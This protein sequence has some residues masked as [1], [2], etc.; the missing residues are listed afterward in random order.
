M[1]RWVR[2][3]GSPPPPAVPSPRSGP[4]G[5]SG[6]DPGGCQG[7]SA[8]PRRAGSLG[9]RGRRLRRSGPDPAPSGQRARAQPGPGGRGGAQERALRPRGP[10]ALRALRPVRGEPSGHGAGPGGRPGGPGVGTVR[11]AGRRGPG[12][13]GAGRPGGAVRPRA[14]GRLPAGRAPPG[15]GHHHPGRHD[16]P[17]RRGPRLRRGRRHGLRGDRRALHRS[18][19]R[20]LRVGSGQAP[21]GQALGRRRGGRPCPVPRLLGQFLRPA[22]ALERGLAPCGQPRPAS[23]RR[24]LP[25]ALADRVL[26]PPGRRPLGGRARALPPAAPIRATRDVPLR[27]AST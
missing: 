27:R 4:V 7:H 25:P 8:S 16:R 2:V 14:P 1:P 6:P 20:W 18:A 3:K 11:G 13:A 26:G 19:R 17:V 15:P 22:P 24:R 5:A 23:Q 21:G 12:R 9:E 10:A